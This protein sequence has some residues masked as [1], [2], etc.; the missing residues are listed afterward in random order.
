MYTVSKHINGDSICH[1]KLIFLSFSI[2]KLQMTRVSVIPNFEFLDYLNLLFIHHT[3]ISVAVVNIS[4]N[5]RI[6]SY[7]KTIHLAI[8]TDCIFWITYETKWVLVLLCYVVWGSVVRS[9][10]KMILKN[11]TMIKWRD[12]R[13]TDVTARSVVQCASLNKSLSFTCTVL[14]WANRR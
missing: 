12:L 1:W 6:R 4:L 5:I 9:Y 7:W 3:E 11:A 14:R 13:C 2:E 8:F 10:Q